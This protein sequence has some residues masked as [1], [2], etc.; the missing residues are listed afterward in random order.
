MIPG[1]HPPRAMSGVE[2]VIAVRGMQQQVPQGFL[3]IDVLGRVVITPRSLLYG[4][5]RSSSLGLQ[6]TIT[7]GTG[8]PTSSGTSASG[9]ST[10]APP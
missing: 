4:T 2:A 8:S 3:P 7:S 6:T 1:I 5:S 9:S 10:A